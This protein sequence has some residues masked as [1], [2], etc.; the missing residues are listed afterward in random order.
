VALSFLGAFF[1]GTVAPAQAAAVRPHAVSWQA[2]AYNAL[3]RFEHGGGTG[4]L[5]RLVTYG[6]HLPAKY[7]QADIAQLY[8]DVEHGKTKYISDDLQYVYEDLTNCSGC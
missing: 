2:E 8:S 5:D 3:I 6:F 1:L 7:D 4:A